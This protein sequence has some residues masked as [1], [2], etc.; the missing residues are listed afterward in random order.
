MCRSKAKYILIRFLMNSELLSE[1]CRD[2][3]SG[4]VQSPRFHEFRRQQRPLRGASA[5]SFLW[6]ANS[7]FPSLP[8]APHLR[9]GGDCGAAPPRVPPP[10]CPRIRVVAKDDRMPPQLFATSAPDDLGPPRCR[11]AEGRSDGRECHRA[12]CARREAHVEVRQRSGG[13]G[14]ASRRR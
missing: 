4:S 10:N 5:F 9:P 2:F 8:R 7:E 12:C 14:P 6:D 13:G 3:L 11:G 1:E